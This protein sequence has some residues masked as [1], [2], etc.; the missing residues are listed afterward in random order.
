MLFISISPKCSA[1]ITIP[2]TALIY[3]SAPHPVP[4]LTGSGRDTLI[5]WEL[6]TGLQGGQCV[7]ACLF[8]HLT[9]LFF[10]PKSS[11]LK[12]FSC[13]FS[14]RWELNW[15]GRVTGHVPQD[16]SSHCIDRRLPVWG[17]SSHG[18]LLFRFLKTWFKELQCATQSQNTDICSTL[19]GFSARAGL[20][21]FGALSGFPPQKKTISY[22]LKSLKNKYPQKFNLTVLVL[23]RKVER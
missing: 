21:L 12:L 23:Y 11:K 2:W 9:F 22:I 8:I 20:S 3:V 13:C 6:K 1:R 5:E 15:R 4:N 14:S 17:S 16:W 10:T 7:S 19:L 18:K